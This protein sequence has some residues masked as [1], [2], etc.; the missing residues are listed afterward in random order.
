MNRERSYRIFF[1]RMAQLAAFVIILTLIACWFN[2]G[3]FPPWKQIQRNYRK[4]LRE[5][6]K[7]PAERSSLIPEIS[8]YQVTIPELNRTDRCMTCH[9]T[10]EISIPDTCSQPFSPH[11]GNHLTYHP[12]SRFGCTICHG[13]QGQA[14]DKQNSFALNPRNDWHQPILSPP[15]L[16]SSCGKCHLSLFS[17]N[18]LLV[19]SKVLDYGRTIF[20]REGCL[21]CHKSRGVGGMLGPDLTA[22]GDKLKHEYNFRNIRG[23]Q[24]VSNW[25]EQHFID[26]EMVSAGSRMLRYDLPKSD[27]EAL[28]TF[29]MGLSDP[30]IPY[31]WIGS[32]VINELKGI[33][34]EFEGLPAYQMTCS[35]CHGKT[36][37]GKPYAIYKTGVPA[38]GFRGFL[39]IASAGYIGF[40]LK[41]G[42]TSQMMTSW[43]PD[44]S[45]FFLGEVM[46]INQYIRSRKPVN[47]SLSDT[48]TLIHSGKGSNKTGEELYH[49]NCETCHGREASGDLAIGFNNPDFFRAASEEYLIYTILRGRMNTAMP[50]W[51]WF[52]N[53][54]MADLTGYINRLRETSFR[55]TGVPTFRMIPKTGTDD[56]ASGAERFHYLCSRCHGEHGE[57]ATGPAIL[58]QD[59]LHTADD[60]FLY[61]TISS[62]RIHTPMHGWIMPGSQEG[63]LQPENISEII[64]YMRSCH[65]TVWEYIFPGPTLGNKNSG[66]QLFNIW[67]A[68]CHGKSGSGLQAPSLHDQVF[69][70]A[71]TNGFILA[72]ITLGRPGTAMP[73]WGDSTGTH[74]A[75][76]AQQRKDL[77]AQIRS[78]QKIHLPVR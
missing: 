11:P 50:S 66:E 20:L 27:L 63:G 47:S 13:G 60:H 30:K 62:G 14:L 46:E 61:Q 7:D 49:R 33:R 32:N 24:T 9:L 17:T 38:I 43:A 37:E 51:S 68:G 77:V 45:G 6:L 10:M 67:C 52:S 76:K 64:S 69:L 73:V 15:F 3:V 70:N 25:L 48:K 72:T 74:P 34:P 4:S 35:A 42:R 5:K 41:Y 59:F 65:D 55:F 56:P 22:Q 54:E 28:A 78:W 40:I 75:L 53:Q 26:P 57:G 44:F 39:S 31:E 12:V 19:Q 71:A 23:I 36:G 18:S 29:V 1:S 8:V 2:E 21:G 16:E 58:N